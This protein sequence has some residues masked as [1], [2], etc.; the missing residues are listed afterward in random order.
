MLKLF[1]KKKDFFK[2]F[3]SVHKI[4]NTKKGTFCILPKEE[5]LKLLNNYPEVFLANRSYITA[6]E[7]KYNSYLGNKPEYIK[8]R[9]NI[10]FLY[11]KFND[12]AEARKFFTVNKFTNFSK[13]KKNNFLFNKLKYIMDIIVFQLNN[14]Y[15]TNKYNQI[16]RRRRNNNFKNNNYNNKNNKN[17]KP[18][19]IYKKDDEDVDMVNLNTGENFALEESAEVTK[20]TT[21]TSNEESLKFS[22]FKNSKKKFVNHNEFPDEL[23]EKIPSKPKEPK[24][25]KRKERQNYQN[26]N[27]QPQRK[28]VNHIKKNIKNNNNNNI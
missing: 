13:R 25:A 19:I 21:V 6:T 4:N 11:F 17:N 8:K 7:E 3:K 20:K 27:S 5:A 18:K 16:F 23:S 1:C 22:K 2:N 9:K 24:E 12:M 28:K 14:K 10:L 26:H 15:L